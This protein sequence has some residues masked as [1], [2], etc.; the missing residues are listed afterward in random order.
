MQN[1]GGEWFSFRLIDTPENIRAVRLAIE[2]LKH[3]EIVEGGNAEDEDIR[4][5]ISTRGTSLSNFKSIKE[6]NK[7]KDVSPEL[8]NE[9]VNLIHGA[10][11]FKG[12]RN[13][14]R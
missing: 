10:Y 4:R 12:G 5:F 3:G 13:N 14:G 7:K 2:L 11:T 1:T 9:L 8:A 6:A